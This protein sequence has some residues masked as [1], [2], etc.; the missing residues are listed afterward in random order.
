MTATILAIAGIA[1]AL[2][3]VTVGIV[4]GRAMRLA[5]DDDR[6]PLDRR[7]ALYV[8]DILAAADL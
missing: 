7:T 1:W 6:A 5:Q 2:A 8:D 3:S 4:I